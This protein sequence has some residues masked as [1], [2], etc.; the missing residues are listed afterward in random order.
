MKGRRKA[1][2]GRKEGREKMGLSGIVGIVRN[3]M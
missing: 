3:I 2:R 1:K